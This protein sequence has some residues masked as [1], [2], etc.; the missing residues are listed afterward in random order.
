MLI[1]DGMYALTSE[2]SLEDAQVIWKTLLAKVMRTELG[3]KRLLQLAIEVLLIPRISDKPERVF[4]SARR[5][6]P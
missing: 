4:S 1:C 3:R 2:S 5:R 6:V